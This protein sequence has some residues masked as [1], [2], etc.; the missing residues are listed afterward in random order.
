MNLFKRA[1]DETPTADTSL[2]TRVR[3][4]IDRLRDANELLGGDPTLAIRNE[5]TPP[6]LIGRL[7]GAVGSSWGSTLEA[8]TPAQLADLEIVRS[9][10][11]AIYASIKQLIEVDLKSLEDAA[12]QAGVPWTSGRFPRLPAQ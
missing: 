8:P 4:M 7:Q 2:Q 12:T 1:I 6:S 3:A 9:K 10:Y 11:S 5:P